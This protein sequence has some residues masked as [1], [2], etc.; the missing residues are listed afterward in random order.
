VDVR[1][2]QA[3]EHDQ[4]AGIEDV[5]RTRAPDVVDPGDA[6][7]LMSLEVDRGWAHAVG[8]HDLAAANDA[9]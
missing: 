1:V 6:G 8:R 5:E 3:R 2:H 9:G 7:D 4:V